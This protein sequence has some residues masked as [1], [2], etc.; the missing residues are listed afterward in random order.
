MTRSD[1]RVVNHALIIS[2]NLPSQQGNLDM[3]WFF[4]GLVMVLLLSVKIVVNLVLFAHPYGSRIPMPSSLSLRWLFVTVFLFSIICV[5]VSLLPADASH[6]L[7]LH[8][9][10]TAPLWSFVLNGIVETERITYCFDKYGNL[11]RLFDLTLQARFVR[12]YEVSDLFQ[13]E[14]TIVSPIY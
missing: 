6:Y 2:D 14:N 5:V 3:S 11:S 4:I 10:A 9:L 1:T 12:C 8:F 13:S 7:A